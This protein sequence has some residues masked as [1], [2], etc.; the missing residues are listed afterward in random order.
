M[1]QIDKQFI[2]FY[3]NIGRAQ[4]FNDNLLTS[5]MALLF[6]EPG[7]VAMEDIAKETGYSLASVSNKVKFLEATGFVKRTTKPGTRKAYLYSEKDFLKVMKQ[8]LIKKNEHV[9]NAAKQRIPDM[10]KENKPKAKTEKQKQKI[11]ILE[12]YL[13]QMLKFEIVIQHMIKEFDKIK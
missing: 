5:I 8:A 11:K 9:I 3:Q 7:E 2:E 13:Q 12:K 1:D 6:L 4:G 10:I